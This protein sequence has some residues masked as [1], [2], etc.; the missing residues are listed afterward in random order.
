VDIRKW[1]NDHPMLMASGLGV[2]ILGIVLITWFRIQNLT[3]SKPRGYYT[4]DDG[5]NFFSD[6]PEKVT[7]FEYKGKQA[8]RAHVFR[9]SDGKQFVGY[10]E[11]V[12]P[13]AGAVIK[14][15]R[16]R[17]PT[18]PP[19]TPAEMGV[20]MSGREFKKPGS[21][22]WVAMNKPEVRDITTVT[23]PDGVPAIEVE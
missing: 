2:V 15:A 16:N 13:E 18:D 9:G 12:T 19:P 14:K 21:K 22:D 3:P 10:L 6:D 17:K 7:P 5:A 1:M 11:R 8:V 20:A 4:V 23:G